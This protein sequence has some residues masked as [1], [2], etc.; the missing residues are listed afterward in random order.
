MPKQR[1][2]RRIDNNGFNARRNVV[3]IGSSAVGDGGVGSHT[4]DIY[5]TPDDV[6]DLITAEL[7]SLGLETAGTWTVDGSVAYI[8]VN[9]GA[10]DSTLQI[11]NS[12]G[13]Y[14]ANV[15]IEGD[16]TVLGSV[17]NT[18]PIT[19]Q[20]WEWATDDNM[21][22][23]ANYADGPS[24]VQ[25]LNDS[26][27]YD[28]SL[29]VEDAIDS[30]GDIT[31]GGDFVGQTLSYPDTALYIEANN[32]AASTVYVR[33][34]DATAKASLNVE[35]DISAGG[36]VTATG[37]LAGVNGTLSGTLSVAGGVINDFFVDTN[38]LFV[39]VSENRV[40]VNDSTPSYALDVNGTFRATGAGTFDTTLG[41]TG[42][43]TL[44][45][46]LNVDSGVLFVD[47]SENRVGV[48]NASPSY[49][50]DVNGTFRVVS[51]SAL[52]GAA[53]L[54]STLNVAGISTFQ[55]DVIMQTAA[56]VGTDLTVTDDVIVGDA[57]TV[58]GTVTLPL[59]SIDGTTGVMQTRSPYAF[60]QGGVGIDTVGI[61][62][63]PADGKID[64]ERALF[65]RF[66][67]ETFVLEEVAVNT[68]D[69][70][71]AKS[72]GVLRS[73]VTIT[74]Q[75]NWTASN[76]DQ[77]VDSA[78]NTFTFRD[79]AAF[80]IALEDPKT[81]HYKLLED[82]D[83]IVIRGRG[84]AE[85]RAYGVGQAFGPHRWYPAL[86]TSDAG[87][88]VPM[89]LR[90]Y[91]SG[92]PVDQTTHWEYTCYPVDE[93]VAELD[94]L[95]FYAGSAVV[96]YGKDGEGWVGIISR[97]NSAY[98]DVGTIDGNQW[99]GGLT[100][101]LRLGDIGGL[102]AVAD[103]GDVGMVG[104]PGIESGTG[105]WFRIAQD[106]VMLQNGTVAVRDSSGTVRTALNST[107][108]NLYMTPYEDQDGNPLTDDG[109]FASAV[110]FVDNIEDV[111][112]TYGGLVGTRFNAIGSN[113]KSDVIA[114]RGELASDATSVTTTMRAGTANTAG[115]SVSTYYNPSQTASGVITLLTSTVD[116]SY[117]R[118]TSAQVQV[119]APK[120]QFAQLPTSPFGLSSGMIW[121]DGGTVKIVS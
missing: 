49:G 46:D 42:V 56:S 33:N 18:G 32:V 74:F 89:E 25:I 31:A 27:T 106:G 16:L 8:D 68:G 45:N 93:Q 47:A 95:T 23:S 52:N 17:F 120:I 110:T 1:F 77:M 20:E 72:G 64:A 114:L 119:Y 24:T 53:T 102:S 71:V 12:D 26:A 96:D 36:D 92:A 11:L 81:G 3:V 117:I 54:G 40:G 50:L 55:S 108:V 118:M 91:V 105:E 86:N 82:G 83:Q 94:S 121:N 67:A 48:N 7:T 5:T 97:A 115:A 29:F 19:G 22:I 38:V 87:Y 85:R 4:H 10:S 34:T 13:T 9:Y 113:S 6:A 28:A 103:P 51:T 69:I 58:S 39:D 116:S 65:D 78:D 57:L 14:K 70:V 111:D 66:Y 21:Y 35:D 62:F 44:A 59:W 63:T 109:V 76:D 75:H 30:G 41:V 100:Q 90:A 101:F 84:L 104:G 15:Q 112:T 88:P 43:T 60:V 98:I 107:G 80:T 37:N 2:A 79:G 73:D 61:R 99:S